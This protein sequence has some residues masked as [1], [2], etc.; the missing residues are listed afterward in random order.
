MTKKDFE[1]V[2]WSLKR[3]GTKTEN[4]QAVALAT[5]ALADSFGAEHPRFNRAKFIAATAVNEHWDRVV[6]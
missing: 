4:W 2:A 5:S 3:L 1:L 6:A